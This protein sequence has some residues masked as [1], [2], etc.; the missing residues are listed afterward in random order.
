MIINGVII[1][2]DGKIKAVGTLGNVPI[3]NGIPVVTAK[4]VTPGLIDAHSVTGLSGAYNVPADQDQDEHSDSNQ[5][6]LRVIDGY[7]PND[8]HLE[9]LRSNG[10]TVIHAMP[11]RANVIAGQTGIFRTAGTTVNQA[12]IR[13]PAGLLINLGESSKGGAGKSPQ[14]RMAS[15]ALARTAFAQ[16]RNHLA[17]K[18]DKTPR[19]LKH[20]GL[21]PMLNGELPVIFSAHRADDIVTGLRIAEEFKLKPILSLAT[22]AYLIPE[23]IVASKAPV[24]V[25]PS[26]QRLAS[27]IETLNGFSGNAAFLADKKVPIAISTAFE[28][29]VP[30]TR[31]LRSEASVAM[32]YGLGRERALRAV[33]IDAAK[34]LGIDKEYG[35]IEAGKVADLVLYD[36]DPFENVSHVTYTVMQGKIVFSRDEYLKLP[37]ARR[38][39]AATQIGGVGCCLGEW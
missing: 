19:N 29:Y 36:G 35:S 30:K 15:A 34:I 17:K 27:S 31:V 38:A 28:G 12:T 23:A 20:E 26:M 7:N 13:F 8:A 2:E 3:P 39:I 11:G 21:Q 32:T 5:S 9:F 1:V 14:T 4:E 10:V 37:F 6:D 18:D 22:E 25:H 16:A 33:T 24:I